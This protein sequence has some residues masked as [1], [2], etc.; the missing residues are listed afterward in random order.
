MPTPTKTSKKNKLTTKGSAKPAPGPK[1][2]DKEVRYS[3]VKPAVKTDMAQVIEAAPSPSPSPPS[4]VAAAAK[5]KEFPIVNAKCKRG[6]D[7]MT[8]G[9]PPCK[10]MTAENMSRP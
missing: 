5:K 9:Q 8:A 4:P 2:P 3:N 7:R 1:A 6:N 10:C